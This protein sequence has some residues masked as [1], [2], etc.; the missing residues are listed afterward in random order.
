[1]VTFRRRAWTPGLNAIKLGVNLIAGDEFVVGAF[2]GDEAAFEDDDLVRVADRAQTVR[3]GD[4]SAAF[5]QS[6][7]RFHHELLR[8][9]VERGG[10]FVENEDGGIAH[11]GAG[12]ADALALA[13]GKREAA[14]ADHRIVAMR[15]LRDE[16]VRIGHLRRL[17][18]FLRRRVGPAVGDVVADRAGE[19]HG[20][21]Q[22]EAD[23]LAQP[24]ELVVSDIGAIDQTRGPASDRRSAG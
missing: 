12:D 22:D 13:A 19:E 11:D 24:V 16:L 6:L 7:E 9:G 17:D 14:F 18:D 23:L 2:L 21:L 15:H 10:R 5:H 1:M 3:D 4:D 8:F 20:V